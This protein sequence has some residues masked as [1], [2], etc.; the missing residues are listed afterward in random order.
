[1]WIALVLA[2][3]VGVPSAQAQD[4]PSPSLTDVT[5]AWVMMLE[6][7]QIALELEQ[8]GEKV[9]GIMHPMGMR[10]LLVGTYVDRTLT[11]KGERPEDQLPH[12]HG[13]EAGPI[14][15]RMLDDGTLEGELST[16][17]GRLKWTG[18]RFKKPQA[19]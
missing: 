1:M 6:G 14:T 8:K 7:H 17:K 18:E 19:R 12:G 11:L 4:K 3:A 10:L 15:A 13:E 2:A 5:G 16:N 9:E